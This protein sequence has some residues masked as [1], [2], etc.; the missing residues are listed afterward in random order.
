MASEKE[1]PKVDGDVHYGSEANMSNVAFVEAGENITAGDAIYVKASDGKAY[2]S[3]TG[4]SADMF[5]DGFCLATVTTG[6]DVSMQTGGIFVT[7]GL[8]DKA[9][10]Y[11]GSAGAISGTVSP[12]QVGIALSTTQLFVNIKDTA[13]GMFPI[14]QDVSYGAVTA[15]YRTA[16]AYSVTANEFTTESAIMIHFECVD[17]GAGANQGIEVE[18]EGGKV[19]LLSQGVIAWHGWLMIYQDPTVN[20]TLRYIAK[21]TGNGTDYSGEAGSVAGLADANWITA[22]RTL[23]VKYWSN[24]GT[25]AGR[26]VQAYKIIKGR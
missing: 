24:A 4:T 15:K 13:N 2:V 11:L 10:Y 23:T 12:I 3:D 25:N 26:F 20:T 14:D 1:F 16:F 22:A 17:D 8:S 5:V 7:S 19:V 18:L 6:N 9:D 21:A